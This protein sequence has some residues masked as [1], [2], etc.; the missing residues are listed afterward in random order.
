MIRKEN[1]VYLVRVKLAILSQS[2]K[3]K[4]NFYFI[5]KQFMF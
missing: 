3:R 5:G 4:Q 1:V 2:G